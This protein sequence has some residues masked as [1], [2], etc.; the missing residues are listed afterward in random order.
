MAAPSS[1]QGRIVAPGP[2]NVHR[3]HA[4][5][6]G[7]QGGFRA[8]RVDADKADELALFSFRTV[9]ISLSDSFNSP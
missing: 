1:D 2:V 9:A 8:F 4:F 7:P 3:P 6:S 5:V